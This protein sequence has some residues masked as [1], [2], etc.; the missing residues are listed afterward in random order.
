MNLNGPVSTVGNYVQR[1]AASRTPKGGTAASAEIGTHVPGAFNPATGEYAADSV[2]AVWSGPVLVASIGAD[3]VRNFGDG[4]VS[5]RTYE[6]TLIDQDKAS[7]AVKPEHVVDLT[8]SQADVDGLRLWVLDAPG[9]ELTA[10][11]TILAE[12]RQDG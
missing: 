10:H 4:P 7:A 9:D 12:E 5:T 3:Q 1:L 8:S 2:T 11:V 6:V